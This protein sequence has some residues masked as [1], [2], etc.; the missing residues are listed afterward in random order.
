MMRR[1]AGAPPE[2]FTPWF[3]QALRE[4]IGR[5]DKEQAA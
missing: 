4:L 3:A 1:A 5:R 2:R